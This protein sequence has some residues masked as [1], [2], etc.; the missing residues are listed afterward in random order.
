MQMRPP[1]RRPRRCPRL[2]AKVAEDLL[3]HRL[4]QDGRKDL[5]LAAA[6]RAV[7]QIEIMRSVAR[8]DDHARTQWRQGGGMPLLR[9][10]PRCPGRWLGARAQAP[11]AVAATGART[12]GVDGATPANRIR[13][14]A[15]VG[16]RTCP[17]PPALARRSHAARREP[18]QLAMRLPAFQALKVNPF[19]HRCRPM[20]PTTRARSP[21]QCASAQAHAG[22]VQVS[23]FKTSGSFASGNPS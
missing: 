4:L 5:E 23:P 1:G 18:R 15:S 21:W 10:P 2:Q 9:M 12:D 22:M 8:R 3:D 11:F 16:R 19:E 6:V 14:P 13:C 7:L 20:Q 17:G